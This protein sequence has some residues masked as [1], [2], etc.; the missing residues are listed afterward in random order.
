MEDFGRI[1]IPYE[2]ETC[3]NYLGKGQGWEMTTLRFG[4]TEE[5]GLKMP[6]IDILVDKT[7]Y[8]L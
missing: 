5:D 4:S 1:P 6:C 3:W 8:S 7:S 2:L